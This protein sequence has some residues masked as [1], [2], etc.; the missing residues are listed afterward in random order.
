MRSII[1]ISLPSQLE[2]VVNKAVKQGKYASKSEFFRYLLRNFIENDLAKEL[3]KS[4]K[5]LTKGNGKLLTSL[6][7]LR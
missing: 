2:A 4:R 1:N 6:K 3:E 5:E 7:D